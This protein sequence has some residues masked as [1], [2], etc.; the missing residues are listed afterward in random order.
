VSVGA[1][2]G[3]S[4]PEIGGRLCGK[5]SSP[6]KMLAVKDNW[7]SANGGASGIVGSRMMAS[8]SGFWF[9]GRKTIFTPSVVPEKYCGNVRIENR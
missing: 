4:I 5:T 3:R 9:R 1:A 8:V 7:A 6:S 2:T